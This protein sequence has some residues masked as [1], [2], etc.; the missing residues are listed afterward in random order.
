MV[1]G[2]GYLLEDPIHCLFLRNF[3]PFKVIHNLLEFRNILQ[4]VHK[5]HIIRNLDPTLRIILNSKHII[6]VPQPLIPKILQIRK[7]V[8][9]LVNQD[10]FLILQFIPLKCKLFQYIVLLLLLLKHGLSLPYVIFCFI[11][12]N[13]LNVIFNGV[14]SPANLIDIVV[15]FL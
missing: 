7:I 13:R 11:N 1:R 15:T 2:W 10:Y 5:I 12:Q 6:K 4:L 9:N 3:T 8:Y 14:Q